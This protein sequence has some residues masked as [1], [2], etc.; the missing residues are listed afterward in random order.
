[1]AT[2]PLRLSIV[3]ANW[4]YARFIGQAIDSALAID[5]PD[6]EVIV[7]DDGST[8]DSRDVIRRYGDRVTPIFQDNA[9]QAAAAST[10]FARAT[11]DVVMFLDADDL[12]DPSIGRELA[13]VW[14]PGI[15]K[16]QFQMK[17][18]DAEGQPTGAKLPQFKGVPSPEE[19]RAWASHAAA[20][21]TPPGSGNAYA[22]AFL[23]QMFP[24]EGSETFADSYLLSAA[25]YLGDVVTIAKPLVSYRVHGRNDGAMSSFD[26]SR[27][28]REV[29]RA[30]WRFAHAQRVAEAAGV[31][32]SD[33]AFRRSLATLPYRL[34]SLRLAPETHPIADDTL[35]K[36]VAD[37]LRAAFVPQGRTPSGVAV[38]VAWT[39]LV[40]FAPRS[41]GKQLAFWRFASTSR[42]KALQQ[43]LA[44]LRVV[45]G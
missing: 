2:A 38:L 32:V 17:I 12:L 21:P 40:A 34:A 18:V 28:G 3:I 45:N 43:A 42:P 39:L 36:I 7:V 11:G 13:A 27:L 23:Q 1:M 29:A 14:R 5:W 26:P 8:D 44:F 30:R 33:V 35:G 19:I 16:V 37:A 24:L 25:P 22:M 6:V 4:N 20:Y 9:G 31:E 41:L 10:G 15:S